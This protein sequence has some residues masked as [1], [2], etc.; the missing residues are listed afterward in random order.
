MSVCL[1]RMASV[2]WAGVLMII[3]VVIG[4]LR[5]RS[6]RVK[7][8]WKWK[9]IRAGEIVVAQGP[10]CPK[11]HLLCSVN[12]FMEHCCPR[13]IALVGGKIDNKAER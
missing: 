12:T 4:L 11:C 3:F 13:A 7:N 8:K 9:V 6:N 2:Y 10:E 5:G 1:I